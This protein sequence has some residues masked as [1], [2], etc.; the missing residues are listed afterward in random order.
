MLVSNIYP[1]ATLLLSSSTLLLLFSATIT[2]TT[3]FVV[4]VPATSSSHRQ[5]CT[6]TTKTTFRLNESSETDPEPVVATPDSASND[7]APTTTSETESKSEDEKPVKP[8]PK[9]K[10]KQQQQQQQQQPPAEPIEID[11]SKLDIRVGLIENAWEHLEADKLYCEE[12]NIGE[13]S[14]VSRNIAS[15]LKAHYKLDDMIGKKVLV[16]ANLKSRKLVG[17]A[18]HGMVLC[19]CKYGDAEDGSDDVVEFVIP[20][21]DSNIGDRVLCEGYENGEP[22]TENAVI[23]K[24]MLKA[25]FPDLKIN[26]DGIAVYKDKPLFTTTT[27]LSSNDNDDE[28]DEV[29]KLPCKAITLTN[30]PIS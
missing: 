8:K 17:F 11:I 4:V 16:L 25:I 18:S 14:G 6:T 13:E 7:K 29:K 23:K 28:E 12:I 24:K 1:L 20:H 3:A 5:Y 21:E 30:V 26:N 15:G 22:A 10:K 27:I 9:K 2:T 19:A